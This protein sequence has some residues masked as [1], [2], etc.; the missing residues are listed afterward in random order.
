MIT[1]IKNRFVTPFIELLKQGITPEK[2]AISVALGFIIGIIPLVGVSTAICAVIA[3]RFDLNLLAIQLV[4]YIAY[5]LQLL[6]YIP[7]IKAGEFITGSQASGLTFEGIKKLFDEGFIYALKV[8]WLA[9]LQG[10][11]VW[12]MITVP[13][14]LGLYYSFAFLFRKIKKKIPA[15]D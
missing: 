7:F 1:S 10:I 5:P 2:L 14:T 4:N 11:I 6:F 8:L 9:N 12:I 13:V 3:L 15:G